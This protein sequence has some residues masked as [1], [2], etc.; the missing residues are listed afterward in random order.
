ML[1]GVC[2]ITLRL[3]GVH[4]LK[5]KRSIVKSLVEKIRRQLKVSAAEVDA[6]DQKDGAVIA[7]A[8]VSLSEAILRDLFTQ[9]ERMAEQAAGA[10]VIDVNVELL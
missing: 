4:S 3:H 5:E 7:L 8:A 2:R 6:L 1:V 10:E 9:A